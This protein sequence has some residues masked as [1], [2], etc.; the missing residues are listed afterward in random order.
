MVGRTANA[1]RIIGTVN[2]KSVKFK[3]SL[4]F[5]SP[6]T[7]EVIKTS[8]VMGLVRN[9]SLTGVIGDIDDFE[10]ADIP[11]MLT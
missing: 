10:L 4:N 7:A 3:W 8:S 6:T 1:I 2:Q 5:R 11:I 9:N